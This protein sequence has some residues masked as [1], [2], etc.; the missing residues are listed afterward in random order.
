MTEVIV[1]VGSRDY[2]YPE[3]VRRYVE[4]LPPNVLV[5]SRGIR[6]VDRQVQTLCENRGIHVACIKALWENYGK[7]ADNKRNHYMAVLADKVVAFWD[8]ESAGTLR[9][10]EKA[11]EL[12]K[13]C[14]VIHG[15]KPV[16]IPW[17]RNAG[18]HH[19][20]DRHPPA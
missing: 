3:L 16:M 11:D 14:F 13:P 7:S 19:A 18:T 10:L 2:M 5:V 6:G 8:G 9:C 15:P 20:E 12:G 4:H 1:V 17:G